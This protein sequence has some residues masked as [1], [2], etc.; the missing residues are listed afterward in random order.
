[1][2]L[3]TVIA[4]SAACLLAAPVFSNV[5]AASMDKPKN[6]KSSA[7][8]PAFTDAEVRKVYKDTGKI[9]LKHGAIKNLDMPGM[10]MQ[11]KVKDAAMLDGINA[12][13]MVAFTAEQ[14]KGALVVTS[15][16]KKT[17]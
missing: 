17:P 6:E 13:D 14:V 3:A 1:M 9:T 16:H 2:K 11:F 12:G 7:T 4:L 10:T 15:I 8:Q 5:M